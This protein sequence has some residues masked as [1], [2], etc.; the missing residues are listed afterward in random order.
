ME[1]WRNEIKYTISYF[2]YEYLKGLLSQIMSL[3]RDEEYWIRSVYF[4]TPYN[5]D[6]KTK[7]LGTN[8]RRKLRLRIYSL[9]D[10]KVKLEIKNKKGDYSHKETLSIE[11]KDALSMIDN[12]ISWMSDYSSNDVF[13]KILAM[14]MSTDL[15]PKVTVDYYREAYFEPFNDIRITFDKK[16]SCSRCIDLYNIPRDTIYNIDVP[17]GDMVMEVK[18]NHFL[19]EYIKSIINSANLTQVSVSKYEAAR[20]MIAGR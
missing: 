14:Y 6:W 12:D 15:R 4:D 3:D 17:G 7:N 8:I 19:P 9:S 18:F 20:Q 11:K 1:V 2:E 13:T 10:E 16:I 5:R